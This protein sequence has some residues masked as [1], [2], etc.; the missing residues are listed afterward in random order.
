MWN[1]YI[2][3]G[4]PAMKYNT[5]VLMSTMIALG[6]FSQAMK[7]EIKFEDDDDEG[8]L[9]NPY[10]DTPEYVRRGVMASGLFGTGERVID[11]F[12]PIYG[13]RTDGLGGWLYNQATGESPTVG[14]V[15]RLGDAT[16]NVAKGDFERAAYQGLKS[17]PGIGPFTDTNKS[18]ASLLTGG[19]WNYKDNKENQ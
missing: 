9:G 14:Y 2:K 15:G 4:T 3:R 11:M 7:D 17:A 5:F 13:Q 8:T 10:L 18:L 12:A 6:F 1:D 16:L 19:G